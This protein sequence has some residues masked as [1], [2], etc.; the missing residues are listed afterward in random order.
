MREQ[1]PAY[2]RLIKE[3]REEMGM[4]QDVFANMCGHTSENARSWTSKVES[5]KIKLSL[6]DVETVANAL[7]I[8]PVDLVITPDNGD[9]IL[10]EISPKDRQLIN[11]INRLSDNGKK[12]IE[13]RIDELLKLE[14]KE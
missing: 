9:P 14:G 12:K 5:G 13:E 1:L 11:R 4:S 6:D 2:A 10:L 8:S 3:I 7:S